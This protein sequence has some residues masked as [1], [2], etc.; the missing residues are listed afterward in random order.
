MPAVHIAMK[1]PSSFG[2]TALRSIIMDGRERVVTP[3]I[4]DKTTP[5]NA[6]LLSSA[7]A[8][9]IV[10]NMSAYI[11]IPATEARITPN[12][13]FSPSTAIMKS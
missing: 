6:P 8:I 4:N 13:L 12:G 7:S 2:F 11:G 9:G 3:I 1:M 5:S 10:P